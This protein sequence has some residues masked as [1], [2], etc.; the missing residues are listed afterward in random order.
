MHLIPIIPSSSDNHAVTAQSKAYSVSAISSLIGRSLEDG[1]S[2][3]LVEGEISGFHPASTG[4]WYFNLK[5]ADSVL[6]SAVFRYSQKGMTVPKDGDLVVCRGAISY[7]AKGGKLTFTVREMRKKGAGALLELIEKRKAY[8]RSKGYFD[9]DRKR[10]IPDDIHTIGVVTSPT[11]AALRDILNVTRRRAPSLDIIIFPCAVQGE[12][13]AATIASRI[14]QADIFSACDVLIVGRGGGSTEDLACFSEPEVIEAIH[15]CGIPVISAVGHEID[16][17]ISDFVADRRAPTPSA[18]AELVTETA[19][20]RRERM[21]KAITISGTLMRNRLISAEKRLASAMNAMGAMEKRVLRYSGRIPSTADLRRMLLLRLQNS[22]S[23]LA[24]AEDDIGISL[25][26]KAVDAE[27]R[28]SDYGELVKRLLSDRSD[29]AARRAEDLGTRSRQNMVDR[30]RKTE[31]RLTVAMRENEALS[32]LSI[33]G[34]GYSVTYMPDGRILR[35]RSDV[36]PGDELRTR[37]AD[38]YAV[39]AVKEIVNEL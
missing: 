4:H 23:R 22:E 21:E 25:K 10:S 13:A 28:L 26:R 7:Y 34:R 12:G 27:R 11:G 14:R 1:F 39:S 37:L 35:K 32:P 9:D 19:F 36:K 17:P 24:F 18:A 3:I 38:G 8:Y 2:D 33:L 5:D 30:F 6:P 15:G 29:R 16:W 31:S 20:R